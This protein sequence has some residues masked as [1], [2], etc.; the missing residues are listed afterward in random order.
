MEEIVVALNNVTE[1]LQNTMP[2]WVSVVGVLVPIALTVISIVLSVRM[3][4]NNQQMQKMLANR[5]MMNQTRQSVLDIYNSYFNGFMI[6]TQAN[7]N[8]AEIF[9][10]DQSYYRWAQD[11]ENASKDISQAY[12]RAKLLLEDEELLLQLSDAQ[13]AFWGLDK[14]VKAYIYTGIPSQTIGNAWQQFSQQH[15]LVVG[16]YVVLFQNRALGEMFSKMCEN[17]YTKDIQQKVTDYLDLVRGDK[18]DAP[19]RKYVQIKEM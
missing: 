4:R 18:F 5:D 16:N 6:L 19:F 9:T 7:G 10:S 12:N 11:V 1:S 2:A 17:T 14:A 3:D 8:I 13:A 15:S